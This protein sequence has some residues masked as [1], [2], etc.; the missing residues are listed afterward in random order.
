MT[1]KHG[2][3]GNNPMWNPK[4][5]FSPASWEEFLQSIGAAEKDTLKHL[6]CRSDIGVKIRRWVIE[7]GRSKYVPE[8]V[9]RAVGFTR[10]HGYAQMYL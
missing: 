6:R 7:N 9:I 5:K 3:W 4:M 10:I 1:P 2:G 8:E